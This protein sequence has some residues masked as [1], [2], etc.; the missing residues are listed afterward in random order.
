MISCLADISFSDLS[1]INEG[2]NVKLAKV[3]LNRFIDVSP[4]AKGQP[5]KS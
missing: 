4:Y 1:N 3:N 2:W 5:T